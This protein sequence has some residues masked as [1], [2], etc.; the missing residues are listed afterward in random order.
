MNAL[1]SR[2][3]TIPACLLA[4]CMASRIA[5][6]GSRLVQ[7]ILWPTARVKFKFPIRWQ[8][9]GISRYTETAA[10]KNT[11]MP[12]PFLCCDRTRCLLRIGTTVP[13]VR[14]TLRLKCRS[15]SRL[16]KKEFAGPTAGAFSTSRRDWFIRPAFV[17]MV[18]AGYKNHFKKT[19][20]ETLTV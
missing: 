19:V 20:N 4:W 11:Q 9:L 2:K 17:P 12:W 14:K 15:H 13:N 5:K 1:N 3:M 6:V 8:D 16:A 10:G 18:C 7:I